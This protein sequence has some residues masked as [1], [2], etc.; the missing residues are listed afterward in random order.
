[1]QRKTAIRLGLTGGIGSG[2]ST[3]AAFLAHRGATVIDADAISR[4][5]TSA[6][7]SAI[8]AIAAEFGAACIQP[9]GAM[10]RNRMRAIIFSDP[11]AKERLERI[12]HPV[13]GREIQ[14]RIAVAEDTH[15]PLIVIEIPLLVE[16]GRWRT[17][18]NR[19]LVVD[20]SIDEQVNRVVRRSGLDETE[21]TRIINAQVDR[22][23]RL[24][25]ADVVIFNQHLS[26]AELRD[27]VDHIG[28]R[29]GI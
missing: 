25:A 9:D 11:A 22:E 12:I 14:A 16:S 19:I 18:L 10:D 21:V 20:C 15:S 29:L 2:K 27:H 24:A 26:L 3:V 5:T 17:L 8:T 6:G 4:S 13:V 28:N 23:A 1:M 7:G